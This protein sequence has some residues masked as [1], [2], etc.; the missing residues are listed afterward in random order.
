MPVRCCWRVREDCSVSLGCDWQCFFNQHP[1]GCESSRDGP[2]V[3]KAAVL[4]STDIACYKSNLIFVC[5]VCLFPSPLL[6]VSFHISDLP[7]NVGSWR[8][9]WGVHLYAPLPPPFGKD[10]AVPQK[11]QVAFHRITQTFRLGKILRVTKSNH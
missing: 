1:P 10:N 6:L 8:R 5:F 7:S 11:K 9:W 3:V 2:L 4:Q